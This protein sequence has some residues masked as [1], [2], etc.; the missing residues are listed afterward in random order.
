VV[1]E[2]EDEGAE[3]GIPATDTEQVEALTDE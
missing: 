2:D 3:N 1:P